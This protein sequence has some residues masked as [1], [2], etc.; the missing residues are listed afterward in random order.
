MWVNAQAIELWIR[1]LGKSYSDLVLREVIPAVPLSRNYEDS[2][3]LEIEPCPGVEL[4][5]WFE[6]QSFDAVYIT[7][8]PQEVA[9]A[10]FYQGDLPSPYNQLKTQEDVHHR[11]G[12]PYRSRGAMSWKD[13]ETEFKMG[14]WDFY[15]TDESLHS[16]CEV[17]FQY[18]E[19]LQITLIGFS[20]K[21][22]AS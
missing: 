17:E 2:Q 10:N 15:M 4:S 3:S 18:D 14:G 11:L 13:G 8:K 6:T 22:K 7:L 19:D 20:T 12:Q 5:F 16:S 1:N 21:N 9:N